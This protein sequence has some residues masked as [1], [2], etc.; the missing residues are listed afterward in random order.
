MFYN[1]ENLFD[2][3]DDPSTA[4]N[5]FLPTGKK[6]WTPAKYQSKIENLAKV[7]VAVGE[8][9]M[10]AIIGLCEVENKKVLNDLFYGTAL[11][12]Y[13]YKIVHYDSPD[14]RGIDVALVYLPERFRLL[15]SHIIRIRYEQKKGK[16]T[17]DILYCKGILMKKD[18]LHIFIN[19]WPSRISGREAEIKRNFVALKLKNTTDSIFS[20]NKN[21]EIIV[22][23]DF[24]DESND[25]SLTKSLGAITIW[26]KT[27][28]ASLYN[29]SSGYYEKNHYGSIKYRGH[30]T[31]FDHVIVSGTL[32]QNKNYYHTDI[33]SYK[34]FNASFLLK[35]DKSHTGYSLLST[36][37]GRNWINGFS[38]HLPVYID[39]FHDK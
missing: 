14:P 31:I 29:L 35:Q 9:D 16:S 20:I 2:T 15:H 5:D 26:E 34:I 39:L 13:Q 37:N 23:G 24:N 36:Y 12:K 38:D 1:V 25:E 11:S 22:M 7:I 4:D 33:S 19:H 3:F 32:L 30:W 10:P 27:S 17:R 18:T 28:T 8:W 6:Y 21:A